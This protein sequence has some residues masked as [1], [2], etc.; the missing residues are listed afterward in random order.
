MT[1]S[2]KSDEQTVAE[3]KAHP[4]AADTA[5]AYA[6]LCGLSL[7]MVVASVWNEAHALFIALRREYSAAGPEIRNFDS[8]W[9]VWT[10]NAPSPNDPE[11]L[12]HANRALLFYKKANSAAIAQH[13][14]DQERPDRLAFANRTLTD[15]W[16]IGADMARLASIIEATRPTASA[17]H[18]GSPAEVPIGNE[19]ELKAHIDAVEANLTKI[20]SAIKAVRTGIAS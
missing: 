15:Y 17:G 4:G 11:A 13:A 12:V 7:P 18:A 1:S 8:A 6:A 14:Q 3:Y 2:E 9:N 10:D 5:R 20:A 16:E 19:D